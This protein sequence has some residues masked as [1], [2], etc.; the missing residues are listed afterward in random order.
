MNH[1]ASAAFWSA[2]GELPERV[3]SLADKNFALLNENPDH[4]SLHFKRIRDDLWSVRI[5]YGYLATLVDY[6][7]LWISIGTPTEY[8]Q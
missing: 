7:L 8:V 2:Y 4:P 5:G 1:Y 6:G 3:R